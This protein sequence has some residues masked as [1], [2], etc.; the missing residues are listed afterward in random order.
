M[1]RG[2]QQIVSNQTLPLSLNCRLG[3]LPT[4]GQLEKNG[5]LYICSVASGHK[6]DGETVYVNTPGTN[7]K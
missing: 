1:S 7:V 5:Y 3:G 2:N 4:T 6:D